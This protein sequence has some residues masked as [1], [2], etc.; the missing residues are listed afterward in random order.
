VKLIPGKLYQHLDCLNAI[1][2]DYEP[3]VYYYSKFDNKLRIESILKERKI[4]LYLNSG[5]YIVT[6]D[7]TLGEKYYTFLSGSKLIHLFK[8]HTLKEIG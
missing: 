2:A 3:S 4:L 5:L 1:S 8:I 7:L 6:N